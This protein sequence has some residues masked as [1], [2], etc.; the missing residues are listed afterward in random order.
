M[1]R[2]DLYENCT[3]CPRACHADRLHGHTGFCRVPAQLQVARAA[4]HMW[5]EPCISGENGSGAVFFS[6]C[7]VGCVFC[8]NQ[9]I[10][11]GKNG[12]LITIDRLADIFIELQDKGAHN[13]NLVTPDHYAPSI[14]DALDLAKGRGLSLPVICNCSGY[15]SVTSLK[16]LEDYIDVWL[17]DFKYCSSELSAR[18]SHAP[19]YFEKACAALAEMYRQTGDAFFN[20]DGMIQKGIIVR[21]LT[22]PGHT[23]D[24]RRILD[25]LHSTYDNHIYISIMNQF[26]PMPQLLPDYEELNRTV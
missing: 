16:L 25:Y 22:L 15:A 12:K 21:H 17:P 4:L 9:P 6:G 14:A 3:L 24:S 7:S 20:D 18:Y 10:A 8:Q 13:I 2:M 19:D 5:E 23:D 11:S 1:S 26:T